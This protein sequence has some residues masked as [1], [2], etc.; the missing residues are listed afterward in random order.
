MAATGSEAPAAT[1]RSGSLNTRRL[2]FIGLAYFSL[3]PALYLNMGF[4]ET[5]AGGPIMPF[6]FI[7]ITLAVIPTAVSFAVMSGRRPSAGSSYTWV[8]ESTS[9][10]LGLW[11]GWV[12]ITT[13]MVVSALYPLSFALFFNALLSYAGVAANT[14]TGIAGGLFSVLVIAFMNHNNVKLSSAIIGTLMILETTFVAVLAVIIVARGGVLGHFSG[15]P[16]DPTGATAGFAG[17]SLGIIFAFLSIAG[18]DS[19]APVAEE[20]HTP[21]R[22]IPLATIAITLL[23]GLFW[24]LSSYAF[25]I[26]VPVSEV[27]R[28]VSQGQ[29][30]PVLPIAQHYIGGFAVLV[31]ITGFTATIASFGAGLYAASR[32]LYAVSR[33]GF[34]PGYFARLHPR[35]ATPWRAEV[36]TLAFATAALLVLALWQGGIGEGYAYA[37]E[38]FVFFVLVLYIFAN[39][40]NIFY[41][42][43]VRRDEFNVWLNGIIPVAGIAID[44][45]ILYKSFFVSELGL[46]FKSGSS[47]VWFSLAWAVIGAIWAIRWRMRRPLATLTLTEHTG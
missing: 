14:W 15:K 40:A 46:P 42:L 23:A 17:I 45:Y 20:A 32:S 4:M 7:V 47:I 12:M 41:H 33:E 38:V 24:T 39:V 43:R 18:V 6:M 2:I 16:F 22:L 44:A 31:S 29:I 30:T 11:L 3:V 34:A 36:A 19:I 5:D 21:R 10:T 26:A 28:Y 9:P 25:A 8:W 37:G 35:F 13:Y 27:A 1:L